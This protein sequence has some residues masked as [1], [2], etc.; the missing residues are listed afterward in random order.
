MKFYDSMNN[1]DFPKGGRERE[2]QHNPTTGVLL[3]RMKVHILP[4]FN[5]KNNHFTHCQGG[6]RIVQ[7]KDISTL[8]SWLH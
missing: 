7:E 5:L 4:V 8:K 3:S 6:G 2:C 1:R